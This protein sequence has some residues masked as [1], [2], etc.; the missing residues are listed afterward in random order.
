MLRPEVNKTDGSFA[1]LAGE[2]VDTP[3]TR[4]AREF[5]ARFYE[6][7]SVAAF[8]PLDVAQ[9]ITDIVNE[10]RSAFLAEPEINNFV[11]AVTKESLHQRDRWG[12]EHDAS[13]SPDEWLWL[14]AYLAT[15]ATQAAR[16]NDRE[17]YLHQ[18][19]TTAAALA[20]WHAQVIAQT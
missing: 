17:K 11:N 15:K 9:K 16:Y 12:A 6:M 10:A 8:V 4:F 20:N 1:T 7:Q 3:A 5:A 18:L 14:I 2:I 19:I 13:K